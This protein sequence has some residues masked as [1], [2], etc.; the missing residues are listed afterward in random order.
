VQ[1]TSKAK[2][3]EDRILKRRTSVRVNQ[4]YA[5]NLLN[6]P[7]VK[8]ALGS[9]DKQQRAAVLSNPLQDDRFSAM[10]AN[11]AFSIDPNNEDY[12]RLHPSA[13][14]R[15]SSAK[16]RSRRANESDEE[17][18]EDVD[19]DNE[20]EAHEAFHN[21][22][23]EDEEEEMSEEDEERE[24]LR[25][26][27]S[28]ADMYEVQQGVQLNDLLSDRSQEKHRVEENAS[29]EERLR[30][31]SRVQTPSSNTIKPA[32][33]TARVASKVRPRGSSSAAAPSVDRRAMGGL[34][35]R[36]SAPVARGKWAA[37]GRGGAGASRG[38]RG[39]GSRGRGRGRG[40]G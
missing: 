1:K 29:I 30:S 28:Q 31:L 33:T 20:M 25:A 15:Q 5:Q 37:R 35:P 40:G 9:E 32:P 4:E 22:G 18:D 27:A 6:Q 34:L 23:S 17:E 36:E 7:K 14:H 21:D 38:S 10:F 24:P 11:E 12:R 3:E 26:V 16:K 39:R 19:S 2:K 13:T 8:K